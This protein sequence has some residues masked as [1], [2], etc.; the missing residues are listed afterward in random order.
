MGRHD[1]AALG[2]GLSFLPAQAVSFAV[3]AGLDSDSLL[4]RSAGQS[5]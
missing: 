4:A 2:K 3:C 5:R 1:S